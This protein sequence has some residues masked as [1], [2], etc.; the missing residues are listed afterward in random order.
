SQNEGLLA[1]MW[2]FP[3]IQMTKTESDLE[4]FLQRS[5]SFSHQF[6]REV[7]KVRHVFSHIIWNLHVVHI[8]YTEKAKQALPYTFVPYH[9]LKKY[10]F[11]VAHK[12][13]QNF[14]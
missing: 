7:G 8:I 13:V 1:N 14:L 10:P 11:S 4:A 9:D 2:Q 3:M 5:L 12:K 6:V